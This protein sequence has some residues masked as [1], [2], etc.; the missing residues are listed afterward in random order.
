MSFKVTAADTI[1]PNPALMQFLA[2]SH[3][4]YIFSQIVPQV[5]NLCF[6]SDLTLKYIELHS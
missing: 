6:T 3:L 5:A 4:V 2:M 1:G